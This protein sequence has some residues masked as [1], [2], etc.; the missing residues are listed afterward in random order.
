MGV[1]VEA[2]IFDIGGVLVRTENWSGRRKW[3][4]L[5]GLAEYALSTLVFDSPEA[6]RACTGVGSDDAVWVQL[7][8]R[9][10]L[11]GD[12]L[13]MLRA[14]FWS[15]DRPNVELLAYIKKLRSRVKTGVL[16]NAWPEMRDLNEQRFGL[17]DVVDHTRYSF[18]IGLLKPQRE[19]YTAILQQLGTTPA[20]SAFVDDSAANIRGAGEL[21]MRTV[22]FVDTASAIVALERLLHPD[23][24]G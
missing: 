23:A 10:G 22:H 2:V 6:V 7:A 9:F 3:E 12:Q 19:A 24:V 5:L 11:S 8:D 1:V 18:Q 15:G 21:G 16:S 20:A 13:K 14:D 17:R 4:R